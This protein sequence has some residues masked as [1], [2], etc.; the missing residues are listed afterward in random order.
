VAAA[1]AARAPEAMWVAWPET[2]SGGLA[3]EGEHLLRARIDRATAIVIGPGLGR[4]AE[5]L[6]L[7]RSV[8]ESARVP[9]VIDADALQ[10]DIVNAGRVARV[11]TP[12]AGEFAR[13]SGER[14]LEEVA[15]EPGRVVVLKGAVTRVAH[16]ATVYHSFF[17]GP[18]LARGGSGDVLA[19]LIGGLLAQT[20]GEP[21]IAAARGVVWHGL[22]ADELA[23]A[24]GQTPVC[25]TQL[26]DFLPAALRAS[27][28]EPM[29]AP[30]LEK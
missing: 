21:L 13:I 23:R 3:L 20:P 28:A 8:V 10:P 7:A 4:E 17:G 9:A 19:G 1:F 5:T 26:L 25:V 18:V 22:A 15:R 16:E 27:C 30:A 6:A 29:Q 2:P 11:V 14:D 12:H 24:R